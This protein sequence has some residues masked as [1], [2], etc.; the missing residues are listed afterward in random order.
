MQDNAFL[1]AVCLKHF[2]KSFFCFVFKDILFFADVAPMNFLNLKKCPFFAFKANS[3]AS[4]N[5][6]SCAENNW[7]YGDRLYYI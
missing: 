5:C 3:T 2:L 6:T 7:Q 1:S 4:L